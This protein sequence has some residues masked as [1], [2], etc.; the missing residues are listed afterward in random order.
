M[1]NIHQYKNT[2]L[3]NE[4]FDNVHQ[5]YDLMNDVMSLG[6]H[7]LWKK[8]FVNMMDFSS[9]QK[10]IDMASGTGDITKLILQ[11]C[12]AE[13]EI[14]RIEPNFKM[15][16]QNISE[17]KEYQ[18]VMH[19]CS[20]AE[21]VPIKN[22]SIDTYCISFGLRNITNLNQALKEVYRVLNRGGKFYCLEFY[23]V[24][25]P[26]LK[27]LY[28]IYSKAIPFLGKVFN[29]N[30]KPYE[31]LTKSIE[32]FYTQEEI[33]KKLTNAGFKNINTKNLF[34]GIATIH[35]AWKFDD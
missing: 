2:N 34:G 7:R 11:S 24:K 29:Q 20:Y 30:S 33:T 5:N 18:N 35:I 31:Y 9:P 32:D 19:L 23:K 25:K 28:E 10:I 12:N 16:S 1:K 13:T 26:L 14:L 15:L 22:S 17:F 27:N 3:V 8:E 21:N 4:V 6:T